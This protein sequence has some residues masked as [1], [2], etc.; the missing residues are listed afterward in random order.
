M[1][2]I[3][4]LNRDKTYKDYKLDFPELDVPGTYAW[5]GTSGKIKR[6][7]H[8]EVYKKASPDVKPQVIESRELEVLE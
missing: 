3:I 6:K 1:R 5:R 8:L 2:E 4:K 7:S